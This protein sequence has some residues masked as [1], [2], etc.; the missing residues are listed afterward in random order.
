MTTKRIKNIKYF[1]SLPLNENPIKLTMFTF[2]TKKQRKK[3]QCKPKP[4]NGI[5]TETLHGYCRLIADSNKRY[6]ICNNF[7]DILH[8]LTDYRFRNAHN[9]FYNISYDFDA[10]VKFLPKDILKELYV[11]KTIRYK[12]AYTIK[13]IPK[14][15]FSIKVN[16]HVHKFYDIATFFDTSLEYASQK[17]LNEHKLLDIINREVLGKDINYWRKNIKNIIKYCIKDAVLTKKLGEFLQNE[18]G[19]KL[20]FHPSSYVSKASVSK[21]YFRLFAD[22]P[23]YL[24]IPKPVLGISL[25]SYSGGRFEV[26]KRGYIE[27]AYSIDI[28]S[29]YPFAMLNLL[30]IRHGKWKKVTEPDD[31]ALMGFYFCKLYVPYMKLA[32]LPF[33]INSLITF[34]CGEFYTYITKLEYDKLKEDIDIQIIRGYEYYDNEPSY[35]I[36]DKIL[37]LYELK[38]N[39]PKEDFRYNLIKIIM[40]SLYGVFYEKTYTG[41]KTYKAGKMFNPVYASYITAN[42][43]MQ[44]WDIIKKYQKHV[45][46]CATDGLLLDKLPDIEYT[47]QLGDFSFEGE[48]ETYIIKSGIYKIEN[49][50][51]S[52]GVRKI[53]K[54]KTPFKSYNNIF[55]YIRDKPYWTIYPVIIERPL[56]LGECLLHTKTLNIK[57]I[58]I[59]TKIKYNININSEKKRV[60]ED[61]FQY[62]KEIFEKHIDSLPIL[63]NNI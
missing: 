30:D 5:D 63:L 52:R 17:Y 38:K 61:K 43:R 23:N 49:K 16:N 55:D 12:S 51:K 54:L 40:N 25:N 9:F 58:N 44:L 45:L 60:F 62:G 28:N 24:D 39:T 59:F 48:G 10:I 29:A 14:K 4:I 21:E 3:K 11:N 50:Y 57:D 32:P 18:F 15:M 53:G 37:E 47:K 13:Y 33:R 46:S 7:D 35:P 34:P 6:K 36:R 26:I 56:H 22:I 41:E 42:C 31:E 20:S 27:K 1:N 8:F 2:R 19:N